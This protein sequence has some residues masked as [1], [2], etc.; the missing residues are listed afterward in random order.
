MSKE[1]ELNNQFEWQQKLELSLQAMCNIIKQHFKYVSPQQEYSLFRLH[2]F[3][4]KYFTLYTFVQFFFWFIL[5]V[6][7]MY[8]FLSLIVCYCTCTVL[9]EAFHTIN[10]RH[11]HLQSFI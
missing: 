7:F 6:L 8:R 5:N 2:G 11:L 9:Q 3:I 10:N 1:K 4:S